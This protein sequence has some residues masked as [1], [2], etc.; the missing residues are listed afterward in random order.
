MRQT[1]LSKRIENK[2]KNEE[3]RRIVQKIKDGEN[4]QTKINQKQIKQTKQNEKTN[5]TNEKLIHRFVL[6][7]CL[8]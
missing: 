6:K 3:D 1:L 2:R 5:E 7:D 4:K 8:T